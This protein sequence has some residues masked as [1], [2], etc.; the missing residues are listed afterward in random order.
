[1]S[2]G[3]TLSND[4]GIPLIKT[5]GV[6]PPCKEDI[7]RKETVG[8]AKGSPDPLEIVKPATFPLISSE[9]SRT[10]PCV[11]SFSFIVAMA[12]VTCPFFCVP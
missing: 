1:M 8:V 12:L 4:P 3:A 10:A 7:P 5:N 2:L 9:A 11:K 6:V